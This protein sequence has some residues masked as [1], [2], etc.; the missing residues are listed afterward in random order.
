MTLA[1]VALWLKAHA[2]LAWPMVS[3]LLILAFRSRTPL[4]WVRLGETKPRAQGLLRFLRGVGLDPVKAL[5]GLSQML[6]GRAS[7]DARDAEIA[8]LRA[9][10]SVLAAAQTSPPADP[11]RGSPGHALPSVMLAV[12]FLG[13]LAIPAG[14]WL[15][16][17]VR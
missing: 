5:E 4:E 6:T 8:M 3:A 16:E 11:P 7:V 13:A 9:R 1:S 10:L 2:L 17:G 14:M 15:C 12:C